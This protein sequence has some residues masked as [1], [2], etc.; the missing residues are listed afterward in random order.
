M[1]I[2]AAFPLSLTRLFLVLGTLF[3][4]PLRDGQARGH[5]KLGGGEYYA[6][7]ET[8]RLRGIINRQKDGR[9][10]AAGASLDGNLL[11]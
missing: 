1:Y 8:L 6:S 5:Y 11:F 7:A 2:K 9:L 4:R 10:R 3:C